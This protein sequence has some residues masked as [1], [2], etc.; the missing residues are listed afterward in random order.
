MIVAEAEHFPVVFARWSGDITVADYEA[1]ALWANEI[2]A[3]ATREH[4]KAVMVVDSRQQGHIDARVRKMMSAESN[5]D[6]YI[7]IW[8]VMG[9]A[10]RLILTALKW[11]HLPV[12]ER[13]HPCATLA[14]A[15]REAIAALDTLGIA[16]P[17]AARP[18]RTH[19]AETDTAPSLRAP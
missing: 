5:N 17:D 4:T 19:R 3:R 6:F 18:F 10:S 9:T 11:L 7:G 2:S 14:Q 13:V 12:I 8:V 15:Y 16:V 1:H